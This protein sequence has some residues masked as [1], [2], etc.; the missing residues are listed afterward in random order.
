MRATQEQLAALTIGQEVAVSISGNYGPRYYTGY[1][2]TKI[3][4]TRRITVANSSGAEYTFRDDGSELA[5]KDSYVRRYLI[6]DVAA[7]RAKGE[8][9]IAYRNAA[10]AVNLVVP[11]LVKATYSKETM[12]KTVAD[13]Q[14]K[15]AAAMLAIEALPA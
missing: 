3:T 2:V 13:L 9:E 1:I 15:L 14:S 11:N 5:S 4:K 6:A 8:K 12:M 10:D 7:V